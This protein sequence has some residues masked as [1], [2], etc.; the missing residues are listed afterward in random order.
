MFVV[1]YFIKWSFVC[2]SRITV[3]FLLNSCVKFACV[4][5]EVLGVSFFQEFMFERRMAVSYIIIIII[6]FFF[7]L[8]TYEYI[9]IMFLEYIYRK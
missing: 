3:V 8:F 4:Q 1:F 7:R 9:L 6:F 5:P 2:T